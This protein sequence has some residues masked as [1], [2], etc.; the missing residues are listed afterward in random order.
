MSGSGILLLFLISSIILLAMGLVL[1]IFVNRYQRR[2]VE[3]DEDLKNKEIEFQKTLL[4]ATL[5]SQEKERFR[6]ASNLHDGLGALLSSIRLKVLMYEEGSEEVKKFT[7]DTAEL[8]SEGIQE[9]RNISHDLLPGSLS[10]Y[11]LTPALKELFN[12]I[13]SPETQLEVIGEPKRL[14]PQSELAFYRIV[15]EL[16]NNSLKHSQANIIRLSV[17]WEP[18]QLKLSYSDDGV[19]FDPEVMSGGLGRY[20]MESRMRSVDGEITL[21][22]S[23]GKGMSCEIVALIENKILAEKK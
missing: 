1:V 3:Q 17:V 6:I 5:E 8:L 14:D 11:G 13:T 7:E 15:Q 18:T 9:V 23:V 2:M 22:S 10:S 4:K 16:V 19:G 21:N 12:K 20:N